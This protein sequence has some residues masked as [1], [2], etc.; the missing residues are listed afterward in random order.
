MAGTN[1]KGSIAALLA[2]IADAAGLATGLYTSPHLE[3]V[4]ERIRV[5]GAAVPTEELGELLRDVLAAA[6]ELGH[7][8]PTY[9]EAMTLA[10]MLH[11]KRRRLDLAVLE[12]GMG[13]RLD[14]TNLADARLAV[15]S[16]IALDHQEFLGSSLTLIAREKAGVLRP[17]QPAV[18]SP[19]VPEAAAAL[20][21]AAERIGARALEAAREVVGMEVRFR[22]LQGL[23]IAFAT[24]RQRYALTSALAGRHQAWNIATAVVAAEQFAA[25]GLPAL[26]PDAIVAGVAACRWPGRLEPIA[27]PGAGTTVLL[28]AAHNPDGCAALVAFLVELERPFTLLF[29]ALADKDV[30]HMLPPLA[31]LASR[32]VL[33]R[34][35]SPRAAPPA[36][37]AA[38][39]PEGKGVILEEEI[40][41]ALELA[42]AGDP[43]LVVACGSI[44]LI[45]TLRTLLGARRGPGR[46]DVG[47]AG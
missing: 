34:P 27:V 17:R 35:S 39:V 7:A 31:A 18:F 47:L 8:S 25:A 43:E 13:G 46:E 9:F 6:T 2:S 29:G 19:Q 5:A 41:A 40:P 33:T 28:D 36:T 42:L 20:L 16:A 44:F 26:G 24:S 4:E 37:L 10:A 11:F 12:V 38:L 14:A 23:E 21:E 32:V 45:G 1:G 3:R 30:A 15:V 22:G